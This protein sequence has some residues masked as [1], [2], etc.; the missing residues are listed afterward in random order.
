VEQDADGR[1]PRRWQGPIYQGLHTKHRPVVAGGGEN[2]PLEVLRCLS[3]WMSV[4]EDRGTVPG[5]LSEV[6]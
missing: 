5:A 4:L 6:L 3:E 1:H 2:L